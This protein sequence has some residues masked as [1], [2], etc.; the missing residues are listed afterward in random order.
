M[1]AVRQIVTKIIPTIIPLAKPRC[2][3]VTIIP[4]RITIT[5]A[6]IK[7]RDMLL[8]HFNF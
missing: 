5:I 2:D 7:R 1:D 3:V 4:I 8:L 6:N